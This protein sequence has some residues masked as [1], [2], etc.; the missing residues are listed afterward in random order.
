MDPTMGN[1]I[2]GT[3]SVPALPAPEPAPAI[4]MSGY[5]SVADMQADQAG[6]TETSG[7]ST[8]TE[9]DTVVSGDVST[10]E[11]FVAALTEPTTTEAQPEPVQPEEPKYPVDGNIDYNKPFEVYRTGTYSDQLTGYSILTYLDGAA[12]PFVIAGT[13]GDDKIVLQ[14][15]GD[16]EDI[17]GDWTVEQIETEPRTKFVRLLVN[18]DRELTVDDE[19]YDSEHE[20]T[21]AYAGETVFGVYPIVIPPRAGQNVEVVEAAP[22]WTGPNDELTDD[23]VTEEEENEDGDVEDNEVSSAPLAPVDDNSANPDAVWVNGRRIV[24]GDAVSAYRQ[25]QGTRTCDVK[26]TRQHSYASLFIQPRDGSNPY[27]ALNKNIRSY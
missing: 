2:F 10:V 13:D 4:G 23:E 8:I 12:Y 3:P 24:P 26:K 16:G 11:A 1:S 6:G 9:G 7:I 27:W 20:A 17:S 22:A 25:R 15:N 19:L 14:F 18:D 5:L 21:S